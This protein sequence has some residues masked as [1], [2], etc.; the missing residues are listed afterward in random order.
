M[1]TRGFTLVELLVAL[2]MLGLIGA[3]TYGVL[4]RTQRT[5]QAQLVR[6][7]NQANVRAGAL[8]LPADLREIGFDTVPNISRTSDIVSFARDRV[9]FLAGR[10]FGIICDFSLTQVTVALPVWGLRDPV[11]T[12]RFR[13][14]VENDLNT[15][16]DDAWVPLPVTAISNVTCPTGERGL[17]LSTALPVVATQVFAGSPVR[18]M[19][20]VEYGIYQAGTEWWLG[21]RSYAGVGSPAWQPVLGPLAPY[22]ADAASGLILDYRTATGGTAGAVFDIRYIDISLRGVGSRATSLG[23]GAARQVDTV[24]VTT[25]VA[26]RNTLRP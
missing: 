11:L 5:Q 15:G 12:D 17:R 8:I 9:R 1:R 23:G 18:W 10:G 3:S 21:Q 24:G 16:V 26:L 25:R 20:E 22:T 7:E 6:A 2:V 19:E 14:F 13:L 4:V